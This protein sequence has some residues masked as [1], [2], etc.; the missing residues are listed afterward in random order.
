M[1]LDGAH[2]LITGASSG[3]GRALA[4]QA[5]ERG[6]AVALVARRAALLEEL[7]A[8]IEDRVGRRPTVVAA[9]L[10]QRGEAGRAAADAQQALGRIDVLVNNAGTGAGGLQWHVG[11]RDEGREAFEV[12][13]WSPIALVAALVPAMRRRRHGAVVNVTS[14]G[15]VFPFPS[16]GHYVASKAALA[17][18]TQTLRLELAGSGVRVVEL[19][20]GPTD[21]AVQGETRLIAGADRALRGVPLGTP[22]GAARA[23][24]RALERRRGG[25]PVVY[26]S[27]NRPVYA[28]PALGRAYGAVARRL[29]GFDAEDP[30]VVRGGSLG[31]PEARAARAAWT[32]RG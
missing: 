4:L 7:A 13:V 19:V 15:Q 26:P 24:V 20:L 28:L 22:E 32:S 18:A 29:A 31:D 23:I 9:D 2:M 16:L 30:R 5:A 14:A 21:T 10:A 1:R 12:N 25:G 27:W 17:L 6:A 8:R 3:V 11:D